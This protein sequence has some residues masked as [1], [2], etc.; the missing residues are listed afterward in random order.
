MNCPSFEN[1]IAYVDGEM[2]AAASQAL[3]THLASGCATCAASRAWYE[4]VKAIAASDDTKDVPRWVLHRALKLFETQPLRGSAVERFSHLIASLVFDSLR[5][6]AL[7]GARA[8]A[9]ADRQLL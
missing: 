1:L 3:V 8:L 2:A 5:R 4:S 9:A 7:A 6:P